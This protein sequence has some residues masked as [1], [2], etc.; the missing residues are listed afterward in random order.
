M[1]TTPLHQLSLASLHNLAQACFQET[2]CQPLA[3]ADLSP[4]VP[5]NL[6]NETLQIIK[7]LISQG[8]SLFQ[9]GILLET[10]SKERL[11]T[12]QNHP[13]AELVWTGPEVAGAV[14]RDTRVVV[15]EL[16][17]KAQFSV[18]LAT[19][20][21]DTSV[22]ADGLFKVLATRMD[23]N[24]SLNVQLFLNINRPHNSFISVGELIQEF[25]D[26]FRQQIWSGQRLPDIFYDPRSLAIKQ[27]LKACLHAK[28][29]VVDEVFVFITSANFTEAAHY[30]NIE[31]GILLRDRAIAKAIH[32]Q[33]NSLVAHHKLCLL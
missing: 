29:V 7:G 9:V 27:E 1:D 12:L 22:K 24:P 19:Y 30:R 23:A 31:T 8:F 4:Y 16:F 32:S 10:I 14:S 11:S 28:C 3:I 17:Q 26:R 20:A 33:F 15:Q 2:I 25:K 5:D 18:L 6:V 13:P 21:I